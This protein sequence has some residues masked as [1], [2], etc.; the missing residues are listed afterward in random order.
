MFMLFKVCLE[1]FCSIFH[2]FQK[3]FRISENVPVFR[4]CS[5]ILKMFMF[6]F[7]GVSNN[8]PISKFVW[9]CVKRR[10][11]KFCLLFLKLFGML[12]FKIF[13]TFQNFYWNFKKMSV[14]PQIVH[15]F[16]CSCFNF[17]SGIS[18]FYVFPPLFPV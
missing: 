11:F 4:D 5:Q 7:S 3:K 8:V 15:F 10:V 13:T 9:K 6:S 12:L 2:N 17:F 16:K 1:W 18:F 14:Y